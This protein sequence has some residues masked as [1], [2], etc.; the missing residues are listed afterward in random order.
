MR[1]QFSN[2]RGFLDVKQYNESIPVHFQKI[3]EGNEEI[4]PLL[5]RIEKLTQDQE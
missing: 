4:N 2:T 3:I 1:N 5:S